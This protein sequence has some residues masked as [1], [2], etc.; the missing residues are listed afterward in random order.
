MTR[1]R[2]SAKRP[3]R[4]QPKTPAAAAPPKIKGAALPSQEEVRVRAYLLWEAAGRPSGDGG[5]FWLQA[6][7]ELC[8]R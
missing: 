5:P 6:E 4:T 1:K 8:N 2:A 7:R 3:V